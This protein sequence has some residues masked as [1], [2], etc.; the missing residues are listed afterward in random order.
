MHKNRANMSQEIELLTEIRDLLQVMA[1]PA[2]AKRDER[3]R[4]AVRVIVGKSQKFASAVMLMDGSQ[5]RTAIAKEAGIDQ[6]N[7]SRLV[8]ALGEESLIAQDDKNPR[9]CI[10]LPQNFFDQKERTA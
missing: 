10:K 9:L 6:G 8:K 5:T 2:L 3:F 7:L 1:E 4:D